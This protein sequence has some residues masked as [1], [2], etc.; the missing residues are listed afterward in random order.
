MEKMGKIEIDIKTD[1]EYLREKYKNLYLED[2][3]EVNKELDNILLEFNAYEKAPK[4]ILTRALYPNENEQIFEKGKFVVRPA[5][6][7]LLDI[8][9]MK[10]SF[11][12]V[13]N[14]DFFVSFIDSLIEWIKEYN[15]YI[16]LGYNLEVLNKAINEIL[17]AYKNSFKISF[18]LG[19]GI[20]DIGNNYIEL[21]LSAEKILSI[22][23]LGLFSEDA[24]W[25]EKY[26]EKF[27]NVLIE[28][29]CPY[30]IVKIKSD[31][32]YELGIYNRKS[33]NKLLRKFVSRR[34]DYVRVGVGYSED[35]SSFALIEKI[36]ITPKE[37]Y[38]FDLDEVMLLDNENPTVQE[39]KKGLTKIVIQYKLNPFE[40]KTNI[41][42]DIPLREYLYKTKLDKM[43]VVK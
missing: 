7:Y 6:R 39:I 16:I 34:I 22:N 42:L 10:T 9:D 30:D 1:M 12:L 31:I 2:I 21:G 3:V 29:S 15:Y 18:S 24:Y 27:L 25:R 35:E 41:V 32:T 13:N 14:S 11:I 28:C 43:E 23:E 40:K 8:K 37:V 36:A 26:I 20:I 19:E 38:N 5:V 17:Q 33:I 4:F